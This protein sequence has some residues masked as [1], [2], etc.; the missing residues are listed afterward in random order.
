MYRN[1]IAGIWIKKGI[2][3]TLISFDENIFC[4][5]LPINVIIR[6]YKDENWY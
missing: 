5:G 1:S 4:I 2:K 3:P 6:I